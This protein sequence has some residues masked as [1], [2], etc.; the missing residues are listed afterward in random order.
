MVTAVTAPPARSAA[1]SPRITI[2]AWPFTL[3]TS[4]TT[5]LGTGEIPQE[6]PFP[7]P[8]S[9]VPQL[10]ARR[11][12]LTVAVA[13]RNPGGFSPAGVVRQG[14]QH[15]RHRLDVGHAPAPWAQAEDPRRRGEPPSELP[16]E[17]RFLFRAQRPARGRV[18]HDAILLPPDGR[19]PRI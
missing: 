2:R 19:H 4:D 9:L 6:V 5:G 15:L 14:L 13:R 16:H 3:E 10:S 1:T 12:I 17:G 11:S 8:E 18:P 7:S